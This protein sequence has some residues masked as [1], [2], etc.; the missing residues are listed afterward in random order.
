MGVLVGVVRGLCVCAGV[1][2]VGVASEVW[3]VGVVRGVVSGCG[4]WCCLWVWS[5][6]WS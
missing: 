1:G 2:V 3:L 6:V 5:G 4:Q